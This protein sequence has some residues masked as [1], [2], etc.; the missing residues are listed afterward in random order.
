MW[1]GQFKDVVEIPDH[2]LDP[3][4]EEDSQGLADEMAD[5]YDRYDDE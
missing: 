2:H 1:I 3:P 4:E 5:E